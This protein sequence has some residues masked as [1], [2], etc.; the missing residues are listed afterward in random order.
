MSYKVAKVAL[1][2]FV[3]E[4]LPWSLELLII[5][6]IEAGITQAIINIALK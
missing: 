4:D 5:K 1:A 6:Y 3:A 2:N